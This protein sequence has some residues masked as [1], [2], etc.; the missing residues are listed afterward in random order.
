MK[1]KREYTSPELQIAYNSGDLPT[2]QIARLPEE[3]LVR[4][5]QQCTSQSY[6]ISSDYIL[7]KISGSDVI[8]PIGSHYDSKFENSMLLP[9]KTAAFLWQIF[10]HPTTEAEAVQKC[11]QHF[12]G[13]R[14]VIEWHICNFIQE[15]TE[16]GIMQTLRMEENQNE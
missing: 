12:D 14:S 4:Y 6:Q 11:I 10:Q 15:L 1:V 8:V 13:P 2:D 9:N 7:R 3:K 5:M 16:N